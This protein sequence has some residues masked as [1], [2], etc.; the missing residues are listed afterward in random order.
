MLFQHQLPLVGEGRLG[1]REVAKAYGADKEREQYVSA[2]GDAG[3]W[4]AELAQFAASRGISVDVHACCAPGAYL[5]L[6]TQSSLVARTGGELCSYPHFTAPSGA[7]A[8]PSASW[9]AGQL[10]PV[11]PVAP[12]VAARLA[13]E[14]A[15]KCARET[16]AEAVLKVRVSPGLK[17]HKYV[18]N[19]EDRAEHEA[20]LAVVDSEKAVLVTLQHDGGEVKDKDDL[21]V[22]AALLYTTASGQRRV[23]VHNLRLI[24][25]ETVQ[26][27]FRHADVDAIMVRNQ[28][29][30]LASR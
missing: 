7:G 6:P 23:R 20:D 4:Y 26:A 2:A 3:R 13:H 1:N 11:A 17:T 25:A 24:A 30:R 27:V 21:F 15:A 16:G 10:A 14:L 12:D 18:G 19:F 28:V 9:P 5:D 8:V 29:R 22:Q